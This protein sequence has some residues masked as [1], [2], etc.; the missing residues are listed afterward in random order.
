[1]QIAIKYDV[2]ENVSIIEFEEEDS[3]DYYVKVKGDILR[4]SFGWM[5]GQDPERFTEKD[6]KELYQY[7]Y[8][9][10]ILEEVESDGT[11]LLS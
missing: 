1:M 7:G 6:L 8:F 4:F 11:I 10:N 5:K 2:D 3:Y 9:D